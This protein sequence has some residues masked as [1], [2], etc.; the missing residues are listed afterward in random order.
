MHTPECQAQIEK[1]KAAIVAW[2]EKWPNYCQE[3]DGAGKHLW[4]EKRDCGYSEPMGE[5]CE[6]TEQGICPRCGAQGIDH[7][8]AEGPCSECGWNFDDSMP[9]H[10]GDY[11]CWE[12]GWQAEEIETERLIAEF[13]DGLP[14]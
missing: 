9:E 1:T 10:L 11:G 13:E 12:I 7:E 5:P 3:C 6:C 14:F 4:F 8:T 2:K